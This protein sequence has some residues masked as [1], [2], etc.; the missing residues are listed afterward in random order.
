MLAPVS[1]LLVPFIVVAGIPHS[2]GR[3]AKQ[4][5]ALL[6]VPVCSGTNQLLIA[7]T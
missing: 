2:R 7:C 1:K 3:S 5:E 6:Q 4:L